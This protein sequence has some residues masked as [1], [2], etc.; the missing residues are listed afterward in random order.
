MRLLAISTGYA[1]P[2]IDFD[3]TIHSIFH[4]ALNLKPADKDLL[5]TL[6]VRGEDDLPQGIRLDSPDGF[7][8]KQLGAGKNVLCRDK[9]L[10]FEN[11]T[12]VV[13]FSQG[14]HWH[15]DLP[16][17]GTD[18]SSPAVMDAWKCVWQSLNECQVRL[19]AEIDAQSL[20]VTGEITKS[21]ISRRA[22][23]A[24]RI[25]IETTRGF[26]FNDLSALTQLIGL[27]NGLTPCG[28]DILVGYL[29][30]LWCTMR[31]FV[32]RRLFVSELSQAVIRLSGRTNDISRTYLHHAACGQVSS[33]LDTLARAISKPENPGQLLLAADSAM[34]SGHTSGMDAVTGLLLGL[35]TWEGETSLAFR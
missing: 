34:Q 3:A 15:C 1:V 32:V 35:A 11:S 24:I 14:R 30:G 4:T 27:G 2:Y 8:F 28:D 18:L 22:G 20:L 31:D 13:D 25:L 23:K 29:A 19:G 17:L 10:I 6:V 33:R 26:K 9:T 16:T 12:F 21:G 5:L 7:S